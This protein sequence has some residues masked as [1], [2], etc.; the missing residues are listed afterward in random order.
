[1]L[2]NVVKKKQVSAASQPHRNGPL[3]CGQWELADPTVPRD[4]TQ[5]YF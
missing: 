5:M 1:M 4:M 3:D 2:F